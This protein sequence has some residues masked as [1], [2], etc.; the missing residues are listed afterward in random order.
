[1]DINKEKIIRLKDQNEETILP[2]MWRRKGQ[3]NVLSMKER[4][5]VVKDKIRI[6]SIHTIGVSGKKER[7]KEK[8]VIFEEKKKIRCG[9]P[10]R[11]EKKNLT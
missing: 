9:S 11:K 2:Q 3:E 8:E 5:R 1:M 4:L 6:S 7:K 10:K